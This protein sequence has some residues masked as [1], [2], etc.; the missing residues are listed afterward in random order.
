MEGAQKSWLFFLGDK[1]NKL[2]S[3]ESVLT[4]IGYSHKE[5]AIKGSTE[6]G[7]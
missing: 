1:V 4:K 7:D 5:E 2:N 3:E 6:L